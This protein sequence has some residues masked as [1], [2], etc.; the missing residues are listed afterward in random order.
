MEG[1]YCIYYR[2]ICFY[3]L[4]NFYSIYTYMLVIC[5]CLQQMYAIILQ[6]CA[7]YEMINNQRGT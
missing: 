5:W 4:I 7:G 3:N 2:G 1:A 6:G